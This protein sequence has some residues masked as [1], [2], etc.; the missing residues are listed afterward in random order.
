MLTS[1]W[2]KRQEAD[3]DGEKCKCGVCLHGMHRDADGSAAPARGERTGVRNGPGQVGPGSVAGACKQ[4][5][6]LF[7][8]ESQGKR[9]GENVRGGAQRHLIPARVDPRDNEREGASSGSKHRMMNHREAQH[10]HRVGAQDG[11]I[12]DDE[13]EARSNEGCEENDDTEIPDSIGISADYASSVLRKHE[14]QQHSNCG[15]SSVGRDD[16]RADVEED[17]MHLSK[18]SSSDAARGRIRPTGP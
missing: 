1:T 11:P 7:E 6:N 18:N 2:K 8:C 3:A 13:Q 15:E 16:D 9:R 5:A 4:S 17:R 14:R 10:P 12:D